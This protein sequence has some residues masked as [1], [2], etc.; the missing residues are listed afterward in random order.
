MR[1]RTLTAPMRRAL[2]AAPDTEA[3]VTRAAGKHGVVTV[4]ALVA[5]GLLTRVRSAQGGRLIYRTAAGTAA[6]A[7][8]A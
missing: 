4:N 3:V 8:R 6:I 7:P 2:R 1:D 5:R